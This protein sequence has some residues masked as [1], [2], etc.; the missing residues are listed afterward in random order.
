MSQHTAILQPGCFYHIYNRA[1]GNEKLFYTTKN[2]VYFLQKYKNH[3]HPVA[4]TFCYCLMPNHFHL[5]ARIKSEMELLNL[6][7][8]QNLSGL[9]LE[10]RISK[11][12]SNF[13]N[14]YS[15][16]INIQE[17]RKG[18]LFMRPF[19]R[20][21]IES[22]PYLQKLIHYIHFNPVKAGICK[23]PDDYKYSSC[24]SLISNSK[25]LLKREETISWFGDKENFIFIHNNPPDLT[26]IDLD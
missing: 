17:K 18:S 4:D 9:K 25:T 21:K 15:K 24:Q 2:F 10:D 6:T 23:T 16:S 11:Q 3:I 26:G 20:K 12:F 19:K 5:I 14:S 8:F 7:G 13:F 1:N 22:K